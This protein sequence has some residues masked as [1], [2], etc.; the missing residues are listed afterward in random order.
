L[1][2]V[3][4][5]LI[6]VRTFALAAALSLM[7]QQALA[8]QSHTEC[9]VE[10]CEAGSTATTY[11]KTSEPYYSCPS[12]ELAT[13]V[14]TILGLVSMQA[15]LGG[16]AMPNISDKTGEPEYTG[17]TKRLVDALREQAHV[18]TFDEA[19]KI[20]TLGRD[21]RRGTVLNMPEN[22][23]VAHVL[24]EGRKQTFWMPIVHLDRV[25]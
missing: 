1:R 24:D 3:T 25:R 2:I 5:L 21:R 18:Q 17:E 16:G 11:F 14:T 10:T 6:L 22:S 19:V 7:I 20:C 9:S 8:Q 13:Y 12:R 23:V 15:I 4:F